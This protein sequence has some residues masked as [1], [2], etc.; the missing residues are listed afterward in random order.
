MPDSSP[1]PTVALLY[2]GG[3]DSSVLLLRLL[4][5]GH[6]VQPL[7]VASGLIWEEAELRAARR[8][9][10]AVATT[11]LAEL[12]TIS[13]P[14]GDLYV[15][16][17]S[18]TGRGVPDANSPDAAVYL[19]GRNPLLVVKARVWCQLHDIEQLAIGCLGTSPFADASPEF[20]AEFAR[21]MDAAV[22]GNVRIA[23]PLAD[24]QHGMRMFRTAP[25]E[26]T[27]SCLAPQRARHCGDCNKCAERRAAFAEA[28]ITD[29][30]RYAD[31]PGLSMP[32][33][34]PVNAAASQAR[35]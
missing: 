6:R 33:E 16:H 13:M 35:G 28:G 34:P 7:Y 24:K 32:Q 12:V 5:T 9:L 2:S 3:L 4:A 18:V 19:P 21:V 11:S 27:L 23:R 29:R 10:A 17:W 31:P 25:L 15:G 8:F 1:Q 22:G 14:L 30:T 20:F 26:L